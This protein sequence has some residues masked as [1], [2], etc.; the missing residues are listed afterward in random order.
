MAQLYDRASPTE[1]VPSLQSP[2]D[3]DSQK[4][5]FIDAMIQSPK[6]KDA[7]CI[8]RKWMMDY[9]RYLYG[10]PSPGP[11]ASGNI[12]FPVDHVHRFVLDQLVSW[13]GDDRDAAASLDRPSN[14]SF[15]RQEQ[16]KKQCHGNPIKV[17]E[18]D[19]ELS[20]AEKGSSSALP[21]TFDDDQLGLEGEETIERAPDQ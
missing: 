16:D 7:V 9:N 11:V 5:W 1:L 17:E 13:F 19:E 8:G 15:K 20:H 6:D 14:A 3:L 4:L 2:P 21:I 12:G 10:G 18:V